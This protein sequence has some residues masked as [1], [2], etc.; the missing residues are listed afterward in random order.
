[1]IIS[2]VL[3][4][5][6]FLFAQVLSVSNVTADETNAVNNSKELDLSFEE[7]ELPAIDPFQS[8][9]A[10]VNN[11]SQ[12]G[13][14]SN[15]PDLGLLGGL[16]LVAV[17]IGDNKRIAVLNSSDGF[18]NNYEEN[19][20]INGNVELIRIFNDSL[21]VQDAE[22]KSYEVRMNDIIKEIKS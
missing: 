9:S 20:K 8:S 22:G 1:M 11:S 19:D 13:T 15:N 12:Q 21:F 4:F 6:L 18:A 10:G 7:E 2:R 5:I 16:K 14:A 3:F 17:I